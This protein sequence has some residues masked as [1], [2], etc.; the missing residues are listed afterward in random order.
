MSSEKTKSI[1]HAELPKGFIMKII[2]EICSDIKRVGMYIDSNGIFMK[3][4][5]N[6]GNLVSL[7]LYRNS[8]H[9]LNVSGRSVETTKSSPVPD[10]ATSM[11]SLCPDK[12]VSIRMTWWT[13]PAP[14]DRREKVAS[15]W[16]VDD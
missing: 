14:S 6:N 13:G 2:A 3:I 7:S 9:P 5:R 15:Q 1:F 10:R 16:H 12:L 8:I 11:I 4:P